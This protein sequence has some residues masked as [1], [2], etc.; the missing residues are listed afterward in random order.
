[1]A[2]WKGG[3]MAGRVARVMDG[4]VTGAGLAGWLGGPVTGRL[5]G[6][7]HIWFETLCFSAHLLLERSK[8]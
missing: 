5:A 2:E 1:M 3:R 6:F 7:W 8:K 4:S